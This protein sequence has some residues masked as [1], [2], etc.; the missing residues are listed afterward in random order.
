MREAIKAYL[1][2]VFEIS[3]STHL[4]AL[5][6]DNIKYVDKLGLQQILR[7]LFFNL[8]LNWL[9]WVVFAEPFRAIITD[10]MNEIYREKYRTNR[11]TKSEILEA[12]RMG[13]LSEVELAD[14]LAKMGY[15]DED[16]EIIEL[17]ALKPASEGDIEEAYR[18]G[19]IDRETY[20]EY[21]RRLGYS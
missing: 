1:A 9:T 17:A 3:L 21:L 13:M 4:T 8:G 19:L 20:H 5:I 15:P 16:I 18:R 14:R 6:A 12:W 10:P 2:T 11:A 7:S